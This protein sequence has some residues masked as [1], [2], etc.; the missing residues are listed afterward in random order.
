MLALTMSGPWRPA[1]LPLIRPPEPPTGS[2]SVRSGELC[3]TGGCNGS[4]YCRGLCRVCYNRNWNALR[5]APNS[6]ARNRPIS[7]N[8]EKK[9]AQLE[10]ELKEARSIYDRVVGMENRLRW[11]KKIT[12]LESAIE[13]LKEEK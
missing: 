9:S 13:E 10:L 12:E 4:V 7:G 2:I 11:L 6:R 1:P 8:A 5:A 3:T